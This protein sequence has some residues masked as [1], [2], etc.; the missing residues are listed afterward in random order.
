MTLSKRSR[1]VLPLAGLALLAGLVT[2]TQQ[3]AGGLPLPA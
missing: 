2:A 3:V 1:V